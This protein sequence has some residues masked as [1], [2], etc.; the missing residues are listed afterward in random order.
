MKFVYLLLSSFLWVVG[1]SWQDKIGDMHKAM[2]EK[3]V[4][5][6]IVTGLDETACT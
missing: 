5:A 6:M 2:E 3:E 1:R 4:D